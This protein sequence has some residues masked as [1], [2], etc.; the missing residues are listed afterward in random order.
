VSA[1]LANFYT[2]FLF[3]EKD[4]PRYTKAFWIM[5]VSAVLGIVSSLLMKHILRK[6]NRKLREQAVRDGRTFNEYIT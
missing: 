5:T 6:A 4:E 2:P 1:Q 3:P